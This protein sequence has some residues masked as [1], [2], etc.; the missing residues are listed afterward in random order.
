MARAD[1][2]ARVLDYDSL[3]QPFDEAQPCGPDLRGDPE[4]RDIEDAPGDFANQKA[5]ELAQVVARCDAFLQ[6]TKDQAPA[7]VALQAALRIGDLALATAALQLIKGYAE[8]Y[9]EDF[10]PGPAEEMAIARINELSALARPA[11]MTLPLQR[12][13]IAQMPA[14][15]L[16]GF[17]ASMI[18]QA[19]EPTPEWSSADETALA[20][21][22]ETGQ[23]S[24]TQARAFRPTREGARTLRLIMRVLSPAARAADDAANVG[25]D[26][27]GLDPATLDTLAL[28]LRDQVQ[29]AHDAL[30]AMSDLLYEINEIY[31]RRAGDSASLGPV[32][33]VI[34]TI[35]GDSTRFLALF[36]IEE[37]VADA[38]EDA[39]DGDDESGE[40]AAGGEGGRSVRA[41][42]FVVTT[43]QSRADVLAAMDAIMR[44]Y[45][46]REPT[47]PVPLMFQRVR[48]WVEMDF[49]QLLNEI[50]PQGLGEATK[51]L[52]TPTE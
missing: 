23:M 21:Q 34:K 49:L 43:P 14:P 52:A 51:L 17:T 19:C 31:D 46:E 25:N 8:E 42:G 29:A 37:V 27:T 45:V 10:H 32:L 40:G 26:D 44:F 20:K 47:S 11:A 4:F 15:S 41:K 39:A 28:G 2:S 48:Q 24:A 5:P 13:S 9:W 16:Q 1:G 12:L 36:K 6:R 7:I 22:V 50:A 30:Q 38:D 3:I 18:A 33:N 35:V